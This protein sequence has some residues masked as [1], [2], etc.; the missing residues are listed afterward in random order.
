VFVT[1]I[2]AECTVRK[3]LNGP[4]INGVVPQGEALADQSQFNDG[5]STLLIVRVTNVNLPDGT[6]L[7]VTLDFTPL[8]SITLSRGEGALRADLGHFGLSRD[9]IRV[10]NDE[11]TILIGGDF[12]TRSGRTGRDL[13]P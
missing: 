8:G 10:N 9:Q 12:T 11:T 1:A 2:V 5:E 7:N 4:A 13:A 6:V 3:M